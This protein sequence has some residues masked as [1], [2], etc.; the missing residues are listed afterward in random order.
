MSVTNL[1]Q[2]ESPS[3]LRVTG[4]HEETGQPRRRDALEANLSFAIEGAKTMFVAHCV[5]PDHF[6]RQ[7]LTPEKGAKSLSSTPNVHASAPGTVPRAHNQRADSS[8]TAVELDKPTQTQMLRHRSR[9]GTQRPMSVLLKATLQSASLKSGQSRGSFVTAS[10]ARRPRP[11][12][13]RISRRKC[14]N[15][16]NSRASTATTNSFPHPLRFR[17]RPA[18]HKVV[19]PHRHGGTSEAVRC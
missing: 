13:P 14:A 18:A 9:G 12:E 3:V 19:A 6:Q 2:T 4:C 10:N 5:A 15:S 8:N 16:V 17:S 11:V 1:V 7:E